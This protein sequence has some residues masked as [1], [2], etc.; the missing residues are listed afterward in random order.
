[1]GLSL[2]M[3]NVGQT[4]MSN[5]KKKQNGK[6][7]LLVE[8]PRANS[9]PLQPFTATNN[10]KNKLLDSGWFQLSMSD[11]QKNIDSSSSVGETM[12]QGF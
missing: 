7:L 1:M 5:H 3:K 9:T 11:K 10:G 2:S 6:A 8:P 12:V 4:N